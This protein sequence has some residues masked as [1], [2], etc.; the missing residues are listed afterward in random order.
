MNKGNRKLYSIFFI[1]VF[2]SMIFITVFSTPIFSVLAVQLD[3]DSSTNISIETLEQNVDNLIV[4]SP[5]T[6][7]YALY[8]NRIVGP[9]IWV[10]HGNDEG[11]SINGKQISWNDFE[12][13]IRSTLN[14]DVVLTCY[15]DNLIKQTS[16]TH[17][18]A[19]T[20]SGVIDAELGA[21]I[22]SLICSQSED[23]E[24][25]FFDRLRLLMYGKE[26]VIPLLLDGRISI[27]PPQFDPGPGGTT[28]YQ[29]GWVEPTRL[30][31]AP[32]PDEYYYFNLSGAEAIYH[33]FHFLL[34]GLTIIYSETATGI[35]ATSSLFSSLPE[36]L[37]ISAL[38]SY[39]VTMFYD[40]F[41]LITDE[42]AVESMLSF[43]GS[44]V[45]E[46]MFFLIEGFYSWYKSRSY[47][48]RTAILGVLVI[49]LL[50][51][52]LLDFW[53]SGACAF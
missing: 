10:G 21:L 33:I 15:S 11:I 53:K 39:V 52:I 4:V 27:G 44:I 13:N 37:F 14:K 41:D 3:D 49:G 31:V 34:I 24:N 46:L 7:T 20:F 6:L 48:E 50:V 45:A 28:E 5:N 51:R 16:L 38:L 32:A 17:Y 47:A 36:Y 12:I 35:M 2:V 23:A 26:D 29:T 18:D 19:Y 42:E 8:I 25:R 30:D 22:T 1:L 40:F 43:A 9:V